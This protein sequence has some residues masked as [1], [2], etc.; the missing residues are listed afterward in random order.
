[1][2]K[3]EET[4]SFR[5]RD[6]LL[7]AA[8]GVG[9]VLL[10]E[11]IFKAP[12][13]RAVY[14]N[15]ET[16]HH[17]V[18]DLT[19]DGWSLRY[20]RRQMRMPPSGRNFEFTVT[21]GDPTQ[22][23]SISANGGTYIQPREDGT[24]SVPV[25]PSTDPVYLTYTEYDYEVPTGG[26]YGN[27]P[28]TS[29]NHLVELRPRYFTGPRE[30]YA[31]VEDFYEVDLGPR[32]TRELYEQ[33]RAFGSF[34]TLHNLYIHDYPTGH[35]GE[36][37]G[38]ANQVHIASGVFLN[39][40]YENQGIGIA[41]HERCHVSRQYM[42]DH[43]QLQNEYIR[44][45]ESYQALGR[46]SGVR[47]NRITR[48]AIYLGL[49]RPPEDTLFRFFDESHYVLQIARNAAA[50]QRLSEAR[51]HSISLHGHPYDNANE[52]FASGA[53]VLRFFANQFLAEFR[54][55]QGEEK[56][57]VQLTAQGILGAFDGMAGRVSDLTQLFPDYL[58]I[59]E[60]VGY[61]VATR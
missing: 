14:R 57:A 4:P 58:R 39:P 32:L 40:E 53:T 45:E 30:E 31:S 17:P 8:G 11:K 28:N 12:P 44:L 7:G 13:E 48:S 16:I 5:R 60:T 46:A 61:T 21:D 43:T 29:Q 2:F 35:G 59:A 56:R 54:A 55:L 36:G 42:Q 15:G 22:T 47:G 33:R 52:M 9:A 25:I 49:D 51:E 19:L 20:D 38:E 10:G 41:F 50:G 18:M 27:R 26:E 37:G 1:M 23:S 6:I 24:E 34:L 3:R